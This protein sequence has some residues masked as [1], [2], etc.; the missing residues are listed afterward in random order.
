MKQDTLKLA[1]CQL[2]TELSLP[3]TL[4]KAAAMVRE[5]AESGAQV[6]LLP[7]MFACPDSP[8]YVP[9]Y[10]EHE[11]LLRETLAAWARENEVLLVG[12]S[13]LERE[14]EALYNSAFV[15][16]PD[17]RQF[18]RHRKVHLFDVDIPGVKLSD[19]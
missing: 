13:I 5:A 16:G 19:S 9:V 4:D 7:E 10:A 11:A 1:L 2:R 3:Q 15:Y 6:V 17:G 18:A 12:G 8:R 14:G